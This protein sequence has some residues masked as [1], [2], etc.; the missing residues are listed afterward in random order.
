MMTGAKL[1]DDLRSKGVRLTVEGEHVA[2]DA[3][4]GVLTEDLRQAIRQHRQELLALLAPSAPAH[5]GA[6][7]VPST[8]VPRPHQEH[9]PPSPPPYPGHPVG[10]PFRPGQRVWLYRW[11][12]QTPRFATPV[13]IVHMRTLW[14]GEQDIGWRNS[15]GELTWHH[16]RLAVAVETQEGSLYPPH[17]RRS[18]ES[19]IVR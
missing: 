16:A 1:L 13:T 8:Q 12:D 15:A 4:Q 14:P 2:L 19:A 18:H 17:T 5:D 10:A 11:D 6:A 9:V 7:T 3:P